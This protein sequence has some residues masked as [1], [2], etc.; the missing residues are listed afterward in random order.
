MLEIK[1]IANHHFWPR[2]EAYQRAKAFT[3]KVM[4]ERIKSSLLDVS[5]VTRVSML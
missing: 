4:S 5:A 2:R 1:R 3:G